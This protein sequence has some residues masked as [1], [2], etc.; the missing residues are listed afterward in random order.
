[1][2]SPD[3]CHAPIA[4]MDP[5]SPVVSIIILTFNQLE[6]TR[7][8]V[9]SVLRNTTVPYELIFVDNA[10]SDGTLD[11]LKTLPNV[12]VVANQE[13]LGFA[14]GNNQG[15]AL[16]RGEYALLLN[17]DA[18]VT[19][20]WLELMVAPMQRD[21]NVGI[22]GPRSNYVAG[23]QLVKDI[24]YE[25]MEDLDAYAAERARTYGDA[26][27]YIS[28]IVGFCMLVRRT[29]VKRI[30]GLDPVFGSGNFEDTDY[31]LRALLAGWV[32]WVAHGA[33]VHH[34]GHRTFIGAGIDWVASMKRNGKIF[35]AKWN[36]RLEGELVAKFD[37][38]DLLARNS[39]NFA[40]DY[41]PLP[42]DLTYVSVTPALAAYHRGVQLLEAGRSDDA[43]AALRDAV[44]GSPSIADFH[45]ALG[46]AYAEAGRLDDA[47]ASLVRAAELAPTSETIQANLADAR[48]LALQA[49]A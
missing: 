44:E 4:P 30:G 10:S 47:I 45:N 26:G 27:D 35:A 2:T 36:V 41:S 24:P 12:R 38:R 34:Y 32:S 37:V 23:H 40:R 7:M 29:V 48:Q 21:P 39:F 19:P 11:Y 5:Q 3:S 25:S 16:A 1:M 13:N 43:V 22:V 9:D 20:G 6:Y 33:F 42:T 14:G 8:C 49:A 17:N 28:C 31:C 15:L 18:I 46:A